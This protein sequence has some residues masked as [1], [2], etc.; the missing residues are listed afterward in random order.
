MFK[1]TLNV[2]AVVVPRAVWCHVGQPK[3]VWIEGLACLALVY[4]ICIE[5]DGT[6]LS[7]YSVHTLKLNN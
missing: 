4:E 5:P 7:T 6:S 3:T 2:R 1:K